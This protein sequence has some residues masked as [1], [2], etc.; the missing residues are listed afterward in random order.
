M[1]KKNVLKVTGAA[2]SANRVMKINLPK[3]ITSAT[4]K[5]WITIQLYV[6]KD[7]G[8]TFGNMQTDNGGWESLNYKPEYNKWFCKELN[9]K[10]GN[11]VR[12]GAGGTGEVEFYVSVIMLGQKTGEILGKD[13][14]ESLGENELAN[15]DSDNYLGLITQ[16]PTYNAGTFGSG[17]H[18]VP[19]ATIGNFMGKENVLKLT[20]A[21]AT[22]QGTFKLSLPK[23]PTQTT[24]TL[25]VYLVAN[26]DDA[27]TPA[28]FG[29]L[30]QENGGWDDT[31]AGTNHRTDFARGEWIT[32]I[33][34]E[35][36]N[37][38]TYNFLYFSFEKNIDEVYIA[39]IWDG[40]VSGKLL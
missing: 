8:S 14:V 19:N 32:I 11:S 39:G 12:I 26:A 10:T 21:N 36:D 9:V 38:G 33:F 27:T 25:Q 4:E 28:R 24:I 31:V 23:A 5:A 40:D 7:G 16:H 3:A 17:A 2:G 37:T 22:C 18:S 20:D 1:G 35:I 30:K 34:T 29:L 13:M 6:V 15:F